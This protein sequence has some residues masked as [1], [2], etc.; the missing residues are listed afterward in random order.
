[1]MYPSLAYIGQCSFK[2]AGVAEKISDRIS[3]HGM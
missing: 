2:Y 1:M 3:D